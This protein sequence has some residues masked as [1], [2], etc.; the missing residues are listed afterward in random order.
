VTSRSLRWA[1]LAA[2]LRTGPLRSDAWVACL[3]VLA[4]ALAV[5]KPFPAVALAAVATALAIQWKRPEAAVYTLVI[6]MGNVKINLYLGFFTLFPEYLVLA[7]AGF[8]W[9]MRTAEDPRPLPEA[10][11]FWRFGIWLVAGAMSIVF[12]PLVAKVVGRVVL[13]VIMA[14]IVLLTL[15]GVRTRKVLARVLAVWEISAAFF[16]LYG[17]VQLVGLATGLDL[18]PRFLERYANPELAVGVGAPLRMRVENIFRANSLFNDP[19]I[20]AGYLSAAMVAT[21]A[22]RTHH[23]AIGRRARAAMETIGLAVMGVCLMLTLSRS[24]FLALAGGLLVLLSQW[25]EALR[26]KR[27]W[28]AVGATVCGIILVA[29]ALDSNPFVLVQRMTGSFDTNDGSNRVHRDVF[30]YGLHLFARYPLTGVGLGNYGEFYGLEADA[31]ARNMMSHSAPL[32]AFA[33]TGLFGGLA[34]VS[35]AFWIASRAWRVMTDRALRARDPGMHAFATAIF[36]AVI[37]VDIANLFYDYYPRTFIWIISGLAI[38]LPRLAGR[39][40]EPERA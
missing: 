8:V 2:G 33:E 9:V 4:A 7:L 12:A 19:N 32:S 34:F 22:L 37:A 30:F 14:A 13:S 29:I 39:A 1:D 15:D 25:P 26:R 31:H 40:G 23:A 16:A 17:I 10:G 6:L 18:S 21:I 20:L 3:A 36:A 28:F 5:W 27:F 24:G 11:F 35:L 38:A